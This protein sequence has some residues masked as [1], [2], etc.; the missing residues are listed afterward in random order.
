MSRKAA[1]AVAK[2][3]E[4]QLALAA[5]VGEETQLIMEMKGQWDVIRAQALLDEGVEEVSEYMK[6]LQ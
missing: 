3:H 5:G 1:D 2:I 4:I 6:K